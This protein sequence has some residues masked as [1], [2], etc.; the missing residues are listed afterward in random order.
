[1]KVEFEISKKTVIY[2]II[3]VLAVILSFITG[4]IVGIKVSYKPADSEP[5]PAPN[6]TDSGC[7]DG[8]IEPKML[9]KPAIYLYGYNNEQVSVALNFSGKVTCTYPK[10]PNNRWA[11]TAKKNG[12]LKSGD[13]EYNYLYWEGVSDTK[14]DFS[15]GYC[16][17]GDKTE[18][19]LE[20]SL[21]TMGL[22]SKEINDFIVYWLPKM[23]NNPY[24]VISFQ[25]KTY[26]DIAKLTVKPAPKRVIRIFMA[27]YPSETEV[28][29]KAQR[30]P[31]PTRK[32]DEPTLIEWGGAMVNGETH[33]SDGLILDEYSIG[34]NDRLIELIAKMSP[35]QLQNV[36]T[37]ASRLKGEDVT[38]AT[39][40]AG[41]KFT[42]K[43]GREYTFT[44]D[45]WAF[46]QNTWAYT[47]KS[48][49][50]IA[51]FTIDEL[52]A[53]IANNYKK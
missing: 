22:N 36:L 42:D 15:Q 23:Q 20:E 16:I 6:W 4:C 9:E 33:Q 3:V 51:Q 52:R 41:H 5:I 13:R 10:A 14:F 50:M 12:T 48:D 31:T 30:L 19:F 26:T 47:G 35:E 25:G 21:E 27:Y 49:A 46:L 24:N 43:T 28:K 7:E 40:P 32:D 1:M 39:Q 37:Q 53:Y 18:R 34:S 17:R 44:D 38:P 45:E 8:Y 2:T 11:V 29:I